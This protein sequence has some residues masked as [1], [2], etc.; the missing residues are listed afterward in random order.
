MP[1]PKIPYIMEGDENVVH[2]NREGDFKRSS[3]KS[4]TLRK[5][6]KAPK[7]F[8]SSYICF[9]VAKQNEIKEELGQ[10]SSVSIHTR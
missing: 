9:F 4:S 5:N 8:K 7:R 2:G 10:D 3:K 6:P 1:R